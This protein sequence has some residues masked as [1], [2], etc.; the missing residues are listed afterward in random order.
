MNVPSEH[1]SANSSKKIEKFLCGKK[2][3]AVRNSVRRGEGSLQQKRRLIA[4]LNQILN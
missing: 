1:H 2:Y 4:L 3:I